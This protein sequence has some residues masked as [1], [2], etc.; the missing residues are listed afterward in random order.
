[1]K[2]TG[3]KCWGVASYHKVKEEKYS[4]HRSEK[5]LSKKQVGKGEIIATLFVGNGYG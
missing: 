1:M 2:V 3:S 5:L 4:L